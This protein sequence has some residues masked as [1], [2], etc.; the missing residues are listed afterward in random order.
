METDHDYFERK[1][2]ELALIARSL[3]GI[4]CPRPRTIEE[5][6]ETKF[7]LGAALRASHALQAW[8]NTQSNWNAGAPL[9]SGPFT[10]RYQYQRADLT[11]TGPFPYRCI[12]RAAGADIEGPLYTCSGMAAISALLLAIANGETSTVV[13]LPGCYKETIE[14]AASYAGLRT[15]P[16]EQDDS[17][18]GA[19]GNRKILWLDVTPFG[20]SAGHLHRC[21]QSADLIVFDTTA[22]SAQSLRIPRFLSWARKARSPVVL[23]RSHTKLDSLGIEYGRLG[24]TM[25]LAF[26]EVPLA[27][28]ARW[29]KTASRT[30]DL[31]RLLGSAALPAHFCPFIGSPAYWQLSSRRSATMLRNDRLL[32]RTL[33]QKLGGAAVRR[34]A[35]GMFAALV[36]PSF[37]SETEAAGEADQLAA[38]LAGRGLPVRHAGSF[39]FDFVAVEGFFDTG[40]NQRL[41]RV[42]MADLPS[43]ICTRVA[44]E[45][46]DWWARRWRIR[47]A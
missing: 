23:V 11:V 5:V 26:P 44:D 9:R 28:L 14:L 16:L 31:I 12:E 38:A 13:H 46:S 27:K 33:M 2:A 7:K 18:N 10:F 29:R 30:R 17:G 6:I 21:A 36:A 24:S 1:H 43:P 40:A 8:G 15:I 34:Y 3:G 47:A 19:Q 32:V 41:L 20:Q 4:D 45:I 25:F 37:W 22:F 42:A 39:G 35:H